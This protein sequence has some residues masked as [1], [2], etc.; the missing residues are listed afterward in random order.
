[1]KLRKKKYLQLTAMPK[2]C[3]EVKCLEKTQQNIPLSD[4]TVQTYFIDWFEMEL[5]VLTPFWVN[6][7]TTAGTERPKQPF[8]VT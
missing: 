6:T 7:S 3:K 5:L 4:K 2:Q 8:M 1:M